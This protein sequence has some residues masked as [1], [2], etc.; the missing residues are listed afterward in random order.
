[1]RRKCLQLYGQQSILGPIFL[2]ENLKFSQIIQW[3]FSLKD[4]N[5]KLVRWRLKLE[6]FDYE[7]VYKTG[8]TNTNA[9]ALSRVEIHTKE[10]QDD[11]QESLINHPGSELQYENPDIIP[12]EIDKALDEFLQDINKNRPSIEDD[13]MTQHT[14]QEEPIIGIP[15]TEK[16][17][18][19]YNNQIILKTVNYL[20]ARTVTEESFPNKNRMHVQLGK[21]NLR[22]DIIMLFKNY[23]S[24]KKKYAILF[25]DEALYHQVSN[26][27]QEIFKNSA[28]DLVKSN[29][30]LEDVNCNQKQKQIITNYHEGKTNHRG[31]NETE[32]QIRKRYYWPNLK[33][34]IEDIINFCDICQANKYDR[35]PEKPVYMLTPTPTRP[36][37]IVHVDTFQ[38][39]GQK[40]L[41]VVDAFSKYGQAYPIDGSNAVNILNAL[42]IFITHH[43]IPHTIVADSGTEFKNG[44]I[45]EFV[46]MHKIKIHYTTPDNPQSNGI[47]ER[48]HSTIIEHIRILRESK[49][50]L[51]I[52][53]QM[54]YALIG[55]NNS[56]HSTTNQKPMEIL[57]G[58]LDS[59][60]PLD[61]DIS[62]TLINN[63]T[64]QHREKTKAI[65][66][67]LNERIRGR[68]QQH[69]EKINSKR[70][71]PITYKPSTKI[72]TRK[73]LKRNKL[74]PRFT[75]KTIKTDNTVTIDT[76]DTTIHKKNI[77]HILLRK[78]ANQNTLQVF[79]NRSPRSPDTRPERQPRNP[80]CQA[81]TSKDTD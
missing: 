24:P 41:T 19:Y 64:Q 70:Q 47:I 63:Y 38:A 3:L 71:A 4:A 29:I 67:E 58:H 26:V 21:N 69:I 62:R 44:L 17:I 42:L 72:F 65:D 60:D 57:N 43:G 12:E 53:E 66:K 59:Q 74:L 13:D 80:A 31:I 54:P 77:K 20:S 11:E 10:V 78:H 9:D 16:P 81:G 35:Q 34:D 32:A 1:M 22:N 79:L 50:S 15:V 48:F 27:I 51:N 36:M 52:K 33:K 56:I 46:N 40:F 61:I 6:E 37:E 7:I 39:S 23:V 73:T 5:S 30:L 45:Q 14:S 2:A 8:K 25:E 76:Q 49:K 55:Y 75:P 68:K 18:N 28:F